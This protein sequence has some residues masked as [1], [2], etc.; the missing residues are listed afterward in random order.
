MKRRALRRPAVFLDRDGV[1]VREMDY[2]SRVEQLS[3]LPGVPAAMK[4]L[5]AAGFK[6][7]VI[8]NQSGV[9]RGYF[10]LTQLGRIHRE[11][12]RRLAKSGAKWD[13]LFFSPHSPESRHPW[14]KPGTGM[15]KA[16]K[17]RFR[18]DLKSS[19]F[20]GD[21]TT[22]VQTARNAGCAAVLVRGG[23]GGKDGKYPKARPDK[24]VRDLPAAARWILS[25]SARKSL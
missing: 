1:I 22:D 25:H 23:H 8:T 20:V 4:A 11:L 9:A 2:L 5:R 3:V 12:K 16:A 24:T 21:T 15:L 18:L 7:V 6:V 17:K 10:S 13:A 19:Y 14:R